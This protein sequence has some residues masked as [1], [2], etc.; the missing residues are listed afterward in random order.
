MEISVF[1]LADK[2]GKE[3]YFAEDSDQMEYTFLDALSI[4]LLNPTW[5]MKTDD[6]GYFYRAYERAALNSDSF[7][8][9]YDIFVATCFVTAITGVAWL[10]MS[11]IEIRQFLDD[12]LA[13]ERRV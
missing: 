8:S 7:W 1:S 10:I 4:K 12:D 2:K 13:F 11:L 5:T 3:V 6:W 9:Q